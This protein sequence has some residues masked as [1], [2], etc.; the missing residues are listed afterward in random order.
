MM[1][2]GTIVCEKL[3]D[4]YHTDEHWSKCYMQVAKQFT[5]LKSIARKFY[6][7]KDELGILKELEKYSEN[8]IKEMINL[9]R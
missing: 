1:N 6:C 3:K 9:N 7:D 8:D 5:E 4:T 2:L